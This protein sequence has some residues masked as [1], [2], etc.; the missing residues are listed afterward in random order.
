MT[1]YSDFD[2]FTEHDASEQ[3]IA[4]ARHLPSGE[5]WRAKNLET[6]TLWLLL[7]AIGGEMERV[8]GAL[9]Y[10]FNELSLIRCIDMITDWETEYGI[11][12]SC[13]ADSIAT[14]TVEERVNNILTKI[15][16]DG[17]NIASAYEELSVKL[18][19]PCKVL[20]GCGA[21]RLTFDFNF[22]ATFQ[23]S[24]SERD[25]RYTIYIEFLHDDAY[26]FTYTFP[27]PLGVDID[28]LL[29]CFFNILKPANCQITYIN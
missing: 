15:S 3:T 4:L 8:E 5:F 9:N 18:G 12:S 29:K 19:S 23:L 25:A 27:F 17:T 22:T 16:A 20:T 24:D 28:S 7:Y 14:Q 2:R 6:S 1:V 26:D 11:P 10:V 21:G 13:F